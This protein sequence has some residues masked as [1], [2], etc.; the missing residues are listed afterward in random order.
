MLCCQLDFRHWS[1]IQDLK[2]DRLYA[3]FGTHGKVQVHFWGKTPNNVKEI[4]CPLRNES[5]IQ[6]ILK[7]LHCLAEVFRRKEAVLVFFK[8]QS[9][10]K[11]H[12]K[13]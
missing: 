12:L 2:A 6:R 11:N 9:E 5:E 13:S 8:V 3:C 1:V 4:L 10:N 7:S